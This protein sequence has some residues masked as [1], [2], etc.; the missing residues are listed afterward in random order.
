MHES[1]PQYGAFGAIT[2]L[3]RGPEA[4]IECPSS[5]LASWYVRRAGAQRPVLTKAWL[6]WVLCCHSPEILNTFLTQGSTFSFGNVPS[7]L[8]F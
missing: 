8:F 2:F 1:H 5:G 4:T 3:K 7:L 6:A